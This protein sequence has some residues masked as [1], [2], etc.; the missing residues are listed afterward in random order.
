[1]SYLFLGFSLLIVLLLIVSRSV[2][3]RYYDK[4]NVNIKK[5][6]DKMLKIIYFAPVIVL[7]IILI[8]TFAYFKSKGFIRIS[9]AWLVVNFWVC[10]VIFY[11]IAIETAKI[12]KLVIL[13]PVVGMVI[14]TF[15][16]IYLTPLQHYES[17]FYNINIIIPDIFGLFMLITSYYTNH[18]LLAKEAKK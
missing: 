5:S 18:K 6:L 3:Y 1:M 16:A 12:R 14:S 10:S 9:H 13:L 4:I 2:F 17:V 15:T 7:F 11:Y 8:L